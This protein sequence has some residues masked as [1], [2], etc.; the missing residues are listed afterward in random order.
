MHLSSCSAHRN[1]YVVP[2]GNLTWLW[3]ITM[4][5]MGKLTMSMAKF[6]SFLYV[7]QRVTIMWLG[8]SILSS[9]HV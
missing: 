4:L 8:N 7:Y 3:K 9:G 5:L 6:H 1:Y 2:S